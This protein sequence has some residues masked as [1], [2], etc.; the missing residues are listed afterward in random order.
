MSKVCR[1]GLQDDRAPKLDGWPHRLSIKAQRV[2][3]TSLP[4]NIH[5]RAAP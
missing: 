4:G 3:A 5:A 2:E 1:G